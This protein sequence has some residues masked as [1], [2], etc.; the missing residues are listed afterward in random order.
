MT[1]EERLRD[2][3]A[4]AERWAV[5][6]GWW[7][8]EAH[9]CALRAAEARARSLVWSIRASRAERWM[10]FW[11]GVHIAIAVSGL[12]AALLLSVIYLRGVYW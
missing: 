2:T 5:E 1:V 3:Q 7:E 12:I 8:D 10:D 9:Q 6:A 11:F 4:D